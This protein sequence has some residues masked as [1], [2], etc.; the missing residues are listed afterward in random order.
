MT[1]Y[2]QFPT[3]YASM[4][5]HEPVKSITAR[6]SYLVGATGVQEVKSTS[7]LSPLLAGF[8]DITLGENLAFDNLR[9]Y[10]LAYAASV[11]AYRCMNVIANQVAALPLKFT[12]RDKKTLLS[13]NH[14]FKLALD[15]GASHLWRAT[16]FDMQIFG[17][18]YWIPVNN[19]NIRRWNPL[20]VRAEKTVYG[21]EF[22]EQQVEALHEVKYPDE[23]V[24]F[25]T[26][27]P[28]DDL[29]SISP[30]SMALRAIGLE[31]S[32]QDFARNFFANNAV[33]GGILTT[34]QRLQEPDAKRTSAQWDKRHS[35]PQ[36]AGKT[37]I[38]D[39]GLTWQALTPVLKDLEMQGVIKD[40][41][42]AICKAYGVPLT[43]ALSDDAANF[44]TAKEQKQGLYTE[45]VLPFAD[46][47]TDVINRQLAPFYGGDCM[48]AVDRDEIEVLQENRVE[49]TQR[50]SRGFSAGYVTLNEARDAEGLP[51]LPGGDTLLL[52][53]QLIPIADLESGKLPVLQPSNPFQLPSG[54]MTMDKQDG[55]QSNIVIEPPVEKAKA[56]SDS[57]CIMYKL[58]AH[59]DLVA[60]QNQLKTQ[61]GEAD[62][63][64][65][66]EFH[67]TLIYAPVTDDEQRRKV[68]DALTSME[69]PLQ[70]L[71]IGSLHTFDNLGTHALHFRVRRHADLLNFQHDL[72]D[73]C[74][75]LGLEMSSYSNPVQYTPHI[76]MGYL[77]ERPAPT[78]FNSKLAL[79]PV[80][81]VMADD[82][83][84]IFEAPLAPEDD[85]AA[86]ATLKHRE[87]IAE[88]KAW[89]TK[90]MRRRKKQFE[91][92]FLPAAVAD[93]IRMDLD[94]AQDSSAMYG[95][96]ESALKALEQGE[97]IA[98]PNEFERYWQGIGGLYDALQSAVTA[99]WQDYRP[100]VAAA[101]REAGDWQA[102]IGAM[103]TALHEKLSQETAQV[104]LAGS[105]RGNDLLNDGRLSANPQKALG[106]EVAWDVI[107]EAAAQW[108]RQ[109]L[110]Q[111]VAYIG[112]TTRQIFAEKVATWVEKGGTLPELADLLDGKP[113][114]YPPEWTPGQL[115]WLLSPERASMIAQTIATETFN[116]GVQTRWKQAG[117]T[118]YR[119]RT[120]ND[121]IVCNVCKGLN[122]KTGKIGQGVLGDDGAYHRIPVHNGCRCFSAPVL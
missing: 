38:L 96:F 99:L 39:S 68:L 1:T 67:V 41:D 20:T 45:T 49:V 52:A 21:I 64:D 87:A 88:L 51:E 14:P 34:E 35:G 114:T 43:I 91:P 97:Q 98:T 115:E 13:E 110:G 71:K 8:H 112:D 55:D 113:V 69:I 95:V 73:L 29:G 6:R 10:A 109:F 17:V 77:D 72:Y 78:I 2:A 44:A 62:W 61:Y 85:S 54:T 19:G 47:I 15:D 65:P 33:L 24:Y 28:Q 12:R 105:A 16:S 18:A 48:V 90:V 104:F 4:Q 59:P 58:G 119:H 31:L 93:F 60:L 101:L 108:A 106:V 81:L 50:T 100:Q 76:T 79:E 86:V 66:A 3:A 23:V 118:D 107:N 27:D 116:E 82:D 117:V 122:N 92:R 42:R 80:A 70:K 74:T 102:V 7:N 40:A 89:K 30:T 26:Y 37:A 46:V 121:R 9:G 57:L 120:Q 94:T 53:G 111:Q 32:I 83:G 84:V 22:F 5:S 36:N 11:T 63:N 56:D 103:D 75:S 25:F